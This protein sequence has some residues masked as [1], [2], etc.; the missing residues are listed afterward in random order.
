MPGEGGTHG[1]APRGAELIAAKWADNRGVPQVVFKPDWTRHQKAAPFKRSA[2]GTCKNVS[3]IGMRMKTYPGAESKIQGKLGLLGGYAL[4]ALRSAS[5]LTSALTSL[6]IWRFL[7]PLPVLANLDEGTRK[8]KVFGKS[9]DEN[10][11]E[12]EKG[13]QDIFGA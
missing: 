6:P 3:D 1:G 9:D 10:I 5:L 7:D 4:W 12:E 13:L 2:D 11:D 8:G